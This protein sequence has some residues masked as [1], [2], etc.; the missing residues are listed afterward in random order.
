MPADLP[1]ALPVS[2]PARLR[3]LLART[4]DTRLDVVHR[5]AHALY[6]AL[7]GAEPRC[8]G[9]VG[10]RATAVPCAVRL[11]APTLHPLT[12]DRAEV[13]DGVLLVDGTALPVRRVVDAAVPRLTRAPAV[14]DPLQGIDPRVA[15]ELAGLTVD[16]AHLDS[17]LGSGG[18]LTPL[19]DD[20]VCGWLAMHRAL[21]APAPEADDVV[22]RAR[23]RTTLLSATL[24]QHAA[25][26][27]VIP[28]FAAWVAA[29]PTDEPARAAALAAVGHSSGAGLLHGARHALLHLS[30]KAVG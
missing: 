27:E 16:P 26:G 5:G 10:S 9:V 17:V 1:A 29:S 2:A 6:L 25:D 22:R 28:E 11:A 18:G 15:A 14:A 24:V 30:R 13:R 21:G 8:V 7:P 19:G 20:V 23:E 12:G 4:P 3:G